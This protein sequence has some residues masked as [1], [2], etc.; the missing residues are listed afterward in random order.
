[1][2]KHNLI[3]L[4]AYID[5]FGGGSRDKLFND[6]AGVVTLMELASKSANYKTRTFQDAFKEYLEWREK[7]SPSKNDEISVSLKIEVFLLEVKSSI[8]LE[9]PTPTPN[10][11]PSVEGYSATV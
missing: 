2:E 5:E 9:S 6:L 10:Q 4:T 1:M 8:S 7:I 3:R 11:H